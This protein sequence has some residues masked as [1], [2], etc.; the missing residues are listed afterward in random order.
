LVGGRVPRITVSR[1]RSIVDYAL[2]VS[3]MLRQASPRVGLIAYGDN[4]C[5]LADVVSAVKSRMGDDVRIV[6]WDVNSRKVKG[7]REPFLYV[8]LEYTPSF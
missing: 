6:S 2:E 4:V 8:E 1:A 7:K 3:V 5:R